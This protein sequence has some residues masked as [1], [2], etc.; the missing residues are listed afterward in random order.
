[1]DPV[2]ALRRV[3]ARYVL[4]AMLERGS[5]KIITMGSQIG[6]IGREGWVHDAAA[7]GGIIALTKALAREIGP[8]GVHVNCITPGPISTGIAPGRR[9]RRHA[10]ARRASTAPLRDDRR[11]RADGDVPGLVRRGLL[12]GANTRP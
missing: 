7:K 9:G 8:P 2:R 4:P 6:K 12:Y 1:V 3:E 10:P 11:C 5:G